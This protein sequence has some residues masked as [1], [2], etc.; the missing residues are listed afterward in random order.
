MRSG[1]FLG[2]VQQLAFV[3]GY[4]ELPISLPDLP[5]TVLEYWIKRF[6]IIPMD[7]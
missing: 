3:G 5:E 7:D 2:E 1:G 6:R 4:G